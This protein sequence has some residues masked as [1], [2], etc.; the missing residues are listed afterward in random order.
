MQS[1]DLHA[2]GAS[3]PLDLELPE[4]GAEPDI[5]GDVCVADSLL[6]API[7]SFDED[8]VVVGT[9]PSSYNERI[10]L[11]VPLALRLEGSEQSPCDAVV[12]NVSTGGIG[13]LAPL[14]LTCSQRVWVRFSLFPGGKAL[15]LLCEVIWCEAE[16]DEEEQMYRVGLRFTALTRIEQGQLF[17]LVREH[18]EGRAG[19]WPLPLLDEDEPIVRGPS[20]LNRTLTAAAGLVA[21]VGLT[22]YLTGDPVPI[23]G[24]DPIADA[25]PVEAPTQAQAEAPAQ[26]E[27]PVPVQV[28]AKAEPMPTLKP[29]L[30]QLQLAEPFMQPRGDSDAMTVTLM[31]DGPVDEHVAFWLQDPKRLVIDIPGRRSAFDSDGYDIAHPLA[32]KLRVGSHRDKVRYVIETDDMVDNAISAESKGNALFVTIKKS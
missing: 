14:R 22:L 21:G 30:E 15:D 10:R 29:A 12:L 25:S 17:E 6:S 9:P 18:V 8:P 19:A 28:V 13:V 7:P 31:T 32:N 1:N 4:L 26:A 16:G 24:H 11:T 27:Q 5:L 2:P 20:L 23:G 3:L